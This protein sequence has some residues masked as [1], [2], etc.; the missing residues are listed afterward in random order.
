MHVRSTR[1]LPYARA[2]GWAKKWLMSSSWLDTGSPGRST[3]QGPSMKPIKS[4]GTTRPWCSS[5]KNTFWQAVPAPP[6]PISADLCSRAVPSIATRLPFEPMSTCWTNSGNSR[7]ASEY[8]TTALV[9]YPKN[10]EFQNPMSPMMT[11]M[12]S[13]RGAW[14]KCSSMS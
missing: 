4:T 9:G 13:L 14:K 3:S 5:W 8:G 2:S 6:K 1:V 11:G 12:L 7:S 10:V